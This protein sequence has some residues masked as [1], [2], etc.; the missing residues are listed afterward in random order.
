MSLN[1]IFTL[2]SVLSRSGMD[3]LAVTTFPDGTLAFPNIKDRLI[4]DTYT[5]QEK[6]MVLDYWNQDDGQLCKS[7]IPVFIASKKLVEVLKT[8]SIQPLVYY[9]NIRLENCRWVVNKAPVTLGL[10]M[11]RVMWAIEQFPGWVKEISSEEKIPVELTGNYLYSYNLPF[12]M[13]LQGWAHYDKT[14]RSLDFVNFHRL[15]KVNLE[16]LTKQKQSRDALKKKY[17]LKRNIKIQ[18]LKKRTHSQTDDILE[19]SKRARHN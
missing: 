3:R 6:I 11:Q 9:T 13:D 4:K 1:N 16:R 8:E 10:I 5:I 12:P 14:N 18:V 2:S 7:D 17:E 15:K 19:S